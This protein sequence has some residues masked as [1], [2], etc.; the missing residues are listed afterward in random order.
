MRVDKICAITGTTGFLGGSIARI[1]EEDGWHVVKLQRRGY[2]TRDDTHEKIVPFT[3]GK[4]ISS[5]IFSDVDV[6]IHCAYDF[7]CRTWQ[8]IEDINV[9]GS[10]RLFDSAIRSGNKRIIY[11]SSM[12]AFEGCKTMY[13]K[14]K[15][16]V[17]KYVLELGG[18]VIRP[19]TIYIEKDGKIYGGQ[20][21]GTLQFFEKLFQISPVVPILHSNKPI[22]YTSHLDDLCSLI[23]EA[24]TLDNIIIE[25]PICAVN[26]NPMTLKEF[27][28][29]IRDRHRKRK[30]LFIPVPWQIP[31][32]LLVLLE[33][34]RV[35]VPFRSES[36]LTFFDQ[37]PDPDFS[38][39][40]YFKTRMRSFPWQ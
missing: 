24:A 28:T 4:G 14:A 9:N 10:K 25:K 2:K 8:E 27:L 23:K 17:E 18:T 5:K 21:G 37:N 33:K 26:E 13:G 15:L 40:K 1:M 19:G 31:W 16:M 22:I 34:I 39:L 20:G 3:L 38:M 36:I 30:C 32:L 11:I 7:K 35:K 29:K 6:L 12:H